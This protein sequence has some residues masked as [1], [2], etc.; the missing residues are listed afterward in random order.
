MKR[1]AFFTI[2]PVILA[3]FSLFGCTP[4]KKEVARNIGFAEK[5]IGDNYVTVL[6][7]ELTDGTI[8]ITLK[9][10]FIDFSLKDF[11][12]ITIR[13]NVNGSPDINYNIDEGK[14]LHSVDV[15]NCPYSGEVTLTFYDSSILSTHNLS[16]YWFHLAYQTDDGIEHSYNF[17]L[18]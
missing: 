10:D 4:E 5:I 13:R 7:G 9:L 2:F 12:S 1:K 3:C 16:Q 6:S 8:T 14:K 11:S 17:T 18:E 15:F